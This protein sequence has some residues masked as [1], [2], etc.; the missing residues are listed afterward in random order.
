MPLSLET[1]SH[2]P[3]FPWCD[4][5]HSH[6]F[7]PLLDSPCQITHPAVMPTRA[8]GFLCNLIY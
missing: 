1:S 7:V 4:F 5:G 3:N 2:L 8:F 6:S